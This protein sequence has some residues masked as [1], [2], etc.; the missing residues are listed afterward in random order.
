MAKSTNAEYNLRIQTVYEMIIKGATRPYIL[1]YAAKEWGTASRQVDT[2]IA[3]ANKIIKTLFSDEKKEDIIN[4]HRAKLADLYVKNYTIEDF[5]EC[6]QVLESER[7]LIGLDDAKKIDHTSQGERIH[8]FNL[9]NLTDEQL[10]VVLKLYDTGEH[11]DT[12]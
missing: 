8:N 10:E 2:Y 4:K 11:T 3:E 12:D 1:R 5:R 7:K 9:S 6:R